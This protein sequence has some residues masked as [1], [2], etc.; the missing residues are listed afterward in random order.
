LSE[1]KIEPALRAKLDEVKGHTIYT[2]AQ[3]GTVVERYKGDL[4]RN[5]FAPLP[6]LQ[7]IQI[8]SVYVEDNTNSARFVLISA[9]RF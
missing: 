8:E 3:D 9:S 6:A 7:P 2:C 4:Y 1:K 5:L